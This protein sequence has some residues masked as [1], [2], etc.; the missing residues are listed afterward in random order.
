MDN[1][2]NYSSYRYFSNLT[3]D[4]MFELFIVI[5]NSSH[6]AYKALLTDLEKLDNRTI[7]VILK[8]FM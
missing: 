2:T 3:V 5:D 7:G 8:L 6:K 4:P 1:N